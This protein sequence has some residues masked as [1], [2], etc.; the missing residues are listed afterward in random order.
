MLIYK[1]IYIY[2]YI[3]QIALQYSLLYATHEYVQFKCLY[4]YINSQQ[5]LL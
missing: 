1:R 4:E 3:H 5:R 2:T